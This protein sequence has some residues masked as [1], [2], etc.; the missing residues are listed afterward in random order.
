MPC[1]LVQVYRSPAAVC[2]LHPQGLCPK[3]GDANTPRPPP[4]AILRASQQ[5]VISQFADYVNES[6]CT[7]KGHLI[8]SQTALNI[9][10]SPA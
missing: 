5:M 3:E 2:Y 10:Q 9:M 4:G 1:S 7:L 6:N 8:L